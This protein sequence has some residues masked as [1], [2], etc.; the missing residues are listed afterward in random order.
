MSGISQTRIRDF[1]GRI[2]FT[3]RVPT[4]RTD[5]RRIRIRHRVL[6]N[7]RRSIRIAFVQ[8][9]VQTGGLVE[10][11]RL[12]PWHRLVHLLV[13]ANVLGQV[14][15]VPHIPNVLLQIDAAGSTCLL[16]PPEPIHRLLG[17]RVQQFHILRQVVHQSDRVRVFDSLQLKAALR[18]EQN[19]GRVQ[20]ERLQEVVDDEEGQSA[21]IS[22]ACSRQVLIRIVNIHSHIGAVLLDCLLEQVLHF[23]LG[24][25][26]PQRT[27]NVRPFDLCACID[28][29]DRPTAV[30]VRH[31]AAHGAGK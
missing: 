21:Q 20:V 19:S 16:V 3:G 27:L 31:W 15:F 12:I 18:F 6:N 1:L 25:S 10:S 28:F 8:Q 11:A 23:G 9:R 17:D 4:H 29:R 2:E 13:H 24:V 30:G 14:Q 5:G 7:L 22:F 26:V